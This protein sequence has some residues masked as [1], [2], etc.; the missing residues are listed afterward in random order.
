LSNNLAASQPVSWTISN[1]QAGTIYFYEVVAE[2]SGGDTNGSI[3]VFQTVPLPPPTLSLSPSNGYF[4]NCTNI[5]VTSSAATVYYTTDGSTPTI[6][7]AEVPM[8]LLTNGMYGGTILWCNPQLSLNALQVL[9]GSGTNTTLEQGGYPATNLVGFPQALS[10]GTGGALYIPVVVELQSNVT[11]QSLQFRVEINTNQGGMLNIAS[12]GLQPLTASDFVPLPGPAPGNTPVTFETFPYT[13]SSHG[14]GLVI[15]AEGGSSGLNMQG[16]GVVVMLHLTIPGTAIYGQSYTLNVLDPSGTSDGQQSSVGLATLPSQTLSIL[17]PQYMVGDSSPST[18]YN[19]EQFGVKGLSN[20]VIEAGL[21]NADVNNAIYASVGIRVPPNDS[22][23]Y[24]AMDAWPPDSAGRGGDGVIGF[25]DWETILGRSVGVAIKTGLDTNNWLRYW[26]NGYSYRQHGLFTNWVAGGPP[27]ALPLDSVADPA[28]SKAEAMLVPSSTLPGFV[29]F[30]EASIE[31]GTITYALPGNTCSLPVYVNV[32]PGYS[33]A[34][35]QFRS[36]V[37]GSSGAP[38]VTTNWFTPAGGVPKPLVLAGL[39][40]NDQVQAWSF[41]TFATALENSNYLGT[42]S[43]QVP[44]NAQPGAC[45]TLHFSGVD[46]APDFTTDYQMESHPGYV[47][48]MSSNLQPA[49][50]TSDEWKIAFFGSLTNSQ[51]GD[52]VDADGDGAPN[53]QEYLAGTNP[54][55]AGSYLQF[56]S[57]SLNTNG[58]RGTAIN[59]LTA[60][61]KTYVLQS[62]PTLNGT[63]WRPINTNSGDGNNYQC[64]VTNMGGNACFY[65]IHLQP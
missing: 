48:V 6:N 55:N 42:V 63:N 27:A 10:A 24:N 64:V 58:V 60:P 15:T 13:T 21:D 4:P 51:A 19:A 2:S 1:L 41:G 29:W 50:I 28:V 54:T 46:G 59:W 22:D 31:S 39:T 43:F 3:I 45:Y 44:T 12:I 53:W 49:S 30:C 26:T 18:G 56:S 20:S 37:S 5:S 17:D 61:G 34:G 65:Q 40:G 8:T 35:M 9:T 57:A 23:I 52:D 33:V 14:Q 11:L 38:E 47:W 25:L 62:S 32:E 36:I 7:S 16:A